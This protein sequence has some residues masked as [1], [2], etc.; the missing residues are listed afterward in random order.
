MAKRASK[1][2]I[3]HDEIRSWAEKRKAKP[4]M[5]RGTGIIR[6]DFPGFSGEKTLAPI[7]WDKWFDRFDASNLAL[8]MEETTARGQRSNFNKLIGRETV[9]MKTGALKSEPRRRAKQGAKRAA[10]TKR[11]GTTKRAAATKRTG[12]TKRAASGATKR[13]ATKRTSTKRPATTRR[14]TKAQGTARGTRRTATSS[15]RR[16]AT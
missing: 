13:T 8:V 2:T 16:A 10:A 11:T 12:A 6:L 5:V 14:T 3:D 1:V 4:A 15:R 7:S 9:D